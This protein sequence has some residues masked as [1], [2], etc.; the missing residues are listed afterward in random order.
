MNSYGTANTRA[1]GAEASG[2]SLEIAPDSLRLGSPHSNIQ[3]IDS[4]GRAFQAQY[5]VSG[6]SQPEDLM[7][8]E[9]SG[10]EGAENLRLMT[11]AGASLS[12]QFFQPRSSG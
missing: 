2:P 12:P 5:M 10:A 4:A 11:A 6:R 3:P 8:N 7:Y 1:P 9:V